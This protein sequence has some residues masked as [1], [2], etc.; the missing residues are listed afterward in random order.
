MSKF[1]SVGGVAQVQRPRTISPELLPLD[2]E[3]IRY[4]DALG[5][6]PND[7]SQ[8]T[9]GRNEETK[10]APLF[11]WLVKVSERNRSSNS[12]PASPLTFEQYAVLGQR[13]NETANQ[14]ESRDS[15]EAVDAKHA[16]LILQNTNSPW[17]AF[18]CGSQ[19]SGKSYSLSC[20][21][22]N[23]L[24]QSDKI[25]RLSKPLTGLVFHYDTHSMGSPCEAAYL[26]SAG[27]PVRVFVSPSNYLSIKRAYSKFESAKGSVS[28]VPL[29]FQDRHLNIERMQKLMAFSDK[30]DGVPL[31]MEVMQD[32][33]LPGTL[34]IPPGPQHI[35]SLPANPSLPGH[36]PNLAK[37]GDYYSRYL[38]LRLRRVQTTT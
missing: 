31:Y 8:D 21:L 7:K 32:V 22:E 24:L 17:S 29:V 12:H 20:M 36:Q 14:Q 25:G 23:C 9:S 18:I 2:A 35:T 38:R 30:E 16:E 13:L 6:D 10:T 33:L 37:N 4:F 26:C 3:F 5:L 11:S 1:H 27:V 34:I 28:V 19:G 15:E